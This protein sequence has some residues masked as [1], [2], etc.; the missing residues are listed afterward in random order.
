VI[1][2][3]I[4]ERAAAAIKTPPAPAN[5]ESLRD[6]RRNSRQ[7]ALEEKAGSSDLGL[8]QHATC[9]MSVLGEISA[10]E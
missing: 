9:G 2:G 6:R 1:A 8:S 4:E 5:Y 7:K 3:W 10:I